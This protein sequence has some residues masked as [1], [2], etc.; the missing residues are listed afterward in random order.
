MA[1][2]R[3]RRNKSLAAYTAATYQDLIDLKSRSNYRSIATSAIDGTSL[4]E[5]IELINKSLQS[6]NYIAGVDGWKI[7]GSGNAEFGNVYVRGD[8]NAYS[9]TIGYWNIS[10]PAVERTFGDTTLF[11]TFLESF[12]HG[13]TDAG[14]TI[15]TY[16]SLFKSYID[17]PIAI[18]S[19]SV[20]SDT[21]TITAP[22]HNFFVGDKIVI[23]FDNAAYAQYESSTYLIVTE[24]TPDTFSYIKSVQNNG[25][26]SSDLADI[27]ASGVAQIYNKDVAGLYLRDYSKSEFDYGYFSNTGI[28]YVSAEDVNLI[29]NPSFEYK[30]DSNVIISST[31][32]WSQGSGLTLA[33]L[34]ISS[35]YSSDSAYGG[36]L[37]WSGTGL[38]TYLSSKIDYSSGSSY[39][40]FNSGKSLYLD[41][42]V[43]PYY[44]P[45][46]KTISSIASWSVGSTWYLKVYSTAHG[47]SA[48]DTVFLDVNATFTKDGVTT[49][50]CPHTIADGTLGYTFTVLSSPAPDTNYFYVN[51][52]PS[53]SFNA[54][55]QTL[56]IASA[57]S[58]SISAYKAY[59]VA[60]DLTAIQFR[61]ENG[62]TTPITDVVSIATKALWD[63][64]KN[65]YLFSNSN[66]YIFSYIKHQNDS[67]F[68]VA[69]MYKTDP[70][71]IDAENLEIDYRSSDI[72]SL[73]N[74]L[75][76]YLD[77]P[78]WLLKHD[79]N[80]VV[81]GTKVTN[82]SGIGYI[83]DNVL[84]STAS[85]FFYG[86]YVGSNRWVDGTNNPAQ[87]SIEDSKTWLNVDLAG[88]SASL[89][90]FDYVGFRN[91][92]FTKTMTNRPSLS[93]SDSLELYVPFSGKN[94]DILTLSSGEYQYLASESSYKNINS[95]LKL[96]T[97]DNNSQFELSTSSRYIDTTTGILD[98][99]VAAVISGNVESSYG[100]ETST[101]RIASDKFVW[102]YL[103]DQM[104]TDERVVFDQDH[105]LLSAPQTTI[106]GDLLVTGGAVYAGGANYSG[107]TSYQR[108]RITSV[109]GVGSGTQGF[110]LGATSSSNLQMDRNSIQG[111]NNSVE[112]AI[113]INASG[114]LVSIGSTSSDVAIKKL[115]VAGYVTNTSGGV[116]GTVATIPNAGL[117]NSAITINGSSVS[118]G[119]SITV[120][121]FSGSGTSITGL[122]SAAGIALPIST[123]NNTTASGAITIATGTSSNSGT[124]TGTLSI[125]T[126]NSASAGTSASGAITIKTGDGFG[127]A[128]S[129]GGVTIDVG[130]SSGTGIAGTINIGASNS[131]TINIGKTS[132]SVSIKP[133]T[134]A[135]YVTNTSDGTL[136]TTTTIPKSVVGLGNVTNESKATMFTDPTFTGTV[137]GITKA[138]VGLGNVDNTSDVN[139]PVSTDQQTALDLKANKNNAVF[140]GTM[141][142]VTSSTSSSVKS[143]TDLVNRAYI[144]SV[145]NPT[146]WKVSVVCATTGALGTTGNLVGGTITTTYNNGTL[147]VGATLTIATSSNWT[148][149]TIDG[150][151]FNTGDRVLIKNQAS[152]FQNGIYTVTTKGTVGTTTSFVFTRATDAD[153]SAENF[154]KHSLYVESG[155]NYADNAFVNIINGDIVMGTT[156]IVYSLGVFNS[157]VPLSG[158]GRIPYTNSSRGI[159]YTSP[160]TKTGQVLKSG[161]AA[162]GADLGWY[163]PVPFDMKT[164]K[165]SSNDWDNVASPVG[166]V[167]V[168]F[169]YPFQTGAVPNI[170]FTPVSTSTTTIFTVTLK[171]APTETGFTAI[172]RTWNG[173]AF[174]VTT[175]PNV[176]W[177]A[178]Q[179]ARIVDTPS[180][181][182]DGRTDYGDVG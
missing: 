34:D 60:L 179:G 127:G 64:G 5:E 66:D 145:V 1:S 174:S 22:D 140:T 104:T 63:S 95:N 173:T 177:T 3:I 134:V 109:D 8:I 36:K 88:Q 90:Y 91:N 128:G 84:L 138:M 168:T 172:I 98:Y 142:S 181:T 116:L 58:V 94:Y 119:G 29:E 54:P 59:E 23:E 41:L 53:G 44:V 43:F 32:S 80:Y 18:T 21:V 121:N 136:G 107:D 106:D 6:S 97:G 112:S 171:S 165:I 149:I 62:T 24:A 151:S 170:T 79:G 49:T 72:D 28:K 139:K 169:D 11:G 68:V 45:V 102:T 118:L 92:T 166:E 74:K 15:G 13:F 38:S 96:I 158:L 124:T 156:D 105:I 162:P 14:A 108:I 103:P 100:S 160:Y 27:A 51:A 78:G 148:A 133:L 39:G 9:G 81:S 123:A 7:D 153:T 55:E 86:S 182:N 65:K 146:T 163:D 122:Q 77:I 155:T 110:Q 73:S 12:D 117:T 89:N 126:G 83:V 31:T 2:R 144:D 61:Y 52:N 137:T 30:D 42:T 167:I 113:D 125:S 164:G 159:T 33:S 57:T 93:M 69:P 20:T 141:P 10:N 82:S 111:Y 56:T 67:T 85:N 70:I 76:F 50:H 99:R 120:A 115:T 143:S 26:S 87:A 157:T 131:P 152:A 132:S 147:G 19:I 71:I 150:Y 48:G 25:D 135:G 178:V 37:T 130:S 175:A 154:E 180:S 17:V 16:V 129:T 161:F 35:L 75:D 114:G 4:A 46:A 47:F 101:I 40:V 176:Y